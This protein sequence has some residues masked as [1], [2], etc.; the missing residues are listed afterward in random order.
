M[1]PLDNHTIAA[2]ADAVAARLRPMLPPPGWPS[3]R[4]LISEPELAQYL[5]VSQDHVRGL[6]RDGLLRGVRVGRSVRYGPDDVAEYLDR[7]RDGA[8]RHGRDTE[9]TGR[10]RLAAS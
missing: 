9:S 6:R 3:A 7:C 5:A 2:I 4:G 8:E 10:A 1:P